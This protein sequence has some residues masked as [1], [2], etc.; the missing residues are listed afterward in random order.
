MFYTLTAVTYLHA[1]PTAIPR[2]L[3]IFQDKK[4]AD[5]YPFSHFIIRTKEWTH[6]K[7]QKISVAHPAEATL[8]CNLFNGLQA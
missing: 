8:E 3:R 4:V 2:E 5:F 7:E 6:H 1:T